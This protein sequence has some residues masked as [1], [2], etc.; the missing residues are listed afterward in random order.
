MVRREGWGGKRGG[1]E[2][3][4]DVEREEAYTTLQRHRQNDHA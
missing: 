2:R 4:R 3:G 1:E